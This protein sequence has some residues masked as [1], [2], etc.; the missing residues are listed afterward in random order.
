M[1]INLPERLQ[2]VQSYVEALFIK[3]QNDKLL[4]HNIEHT[5]KVVQ[6]CNEIS[7]AYVINKTDI[8]ILT[9]AAWFHDVGHLF[10]TPPNHE[11]MSV[12]IMKSYFKKE[13]PGHEVINAI[14]A[15]IMATKIPHD[16][17]TLPEKIICDAD[18]YHLG[19]AEF[20][21][22]DEKLK[23]ELQLRI[24]FPVADWDRTTLNMLIN[25]EYF[26]SYCLELLNKGK[27]KN[28]ALVIKRLKDNL[29]M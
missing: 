12:E 27:Q 7:A 19:T 4:Y 3:F 5:Q 11:D 21:H 9:V 23:R 2:E 20:I 8:Y 26:T 6:R 18:T 28:I 29:Q 1:A 10:G 14:A 24:N 22:T 15:C 13:T 25:H 17:K 16:P